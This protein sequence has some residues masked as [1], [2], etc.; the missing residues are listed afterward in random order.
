LIQRDDGDH[1]FNKATQGGAAGAAL[2][3]TTGN[4]VLMA[5]T[6]AVGTAFGA[7]G[8]AIDNSENNKD[9]KAKINALTEEY[10]KNGMAAFEQ[11]NLEALGF[12]NVSEEYIE[13]VK[14]VV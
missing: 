10:R 6:T 1:V 7:I 14:G 3:L 13:S 9:E 2:G 5:I 8:G 12:K 4:P 11:S